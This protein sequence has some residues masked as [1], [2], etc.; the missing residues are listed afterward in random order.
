M[1]AAAMQNI[2]THKNVL[3][4]RFLIADIP[5]NQQKA[6]QS[7]LLRLR[8]RKFSLNRHQML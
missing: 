3:Q 5:K 2:S 7:F 8:S 1:P 6:L 4:S